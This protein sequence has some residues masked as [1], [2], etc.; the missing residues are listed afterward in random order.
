MKQKPWSLIILAWLHILAP[1]GNIC[2]NA[3]INGRTLPEQWHFWFKVLPPQLTFFYI[4]IPM[5]AGIAILICRRWSYFLYLGCLFIYFLS[6]TFSLITNPNLAYFIAF[7]FVL[8]LDVVLVAYF[9]VPSVQKVYFDERVRWWESARRYHADLKCSLEGRSATIKNIALGGVLIE[10]SDGSIGEGEVIKLQTQEGDLT[11][12][13]NAQ[14][15]YKS[16][17]GAGEP[18]RYGL[19]F[20][21]MPSLQFKSL[22]QYVDK[23]DQEGKV[24]VERLPGKNEQFFPWLKKLFTTG[25]GL[26]PKLR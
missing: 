2:L 8:I 23:L 14:V 10:S 26:I 7:A 6:N 4:A 9:V 20:A 13:I 21:Q 1:L 15:V 22:K 24:I 25:Q 3:F 17:G 18:S 19:K 12:D 16:K 11:L 5:I